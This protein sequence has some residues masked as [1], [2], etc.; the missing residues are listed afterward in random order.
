MGRRTKYEN[1]IHRIAEREIRKYHLKKKNKGLSILEKMDKLEHKLDDEAL[2]K[3]HFSISCPVCGRNLN[4]GG[5]IVDKG[6]LKNLVDDTA[7][8]I[9]M[10]QCDKCMRKSIWS[11]D[12]APAP[13]YINMKSLKKHDFYIWKWEKIPDAHIK[14]R[15]DLCQT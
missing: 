12:I 1:I 15:R 3:Y 9:Y 11:F 4:Y 13:I 2:K 5:H 6:E 7:T 14:Y 10:Y 8:D